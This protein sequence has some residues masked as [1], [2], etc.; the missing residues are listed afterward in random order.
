MVWF[1]WFLFIEYFI[2]NFDDF[3]FLIM[4]IDYYYKNKHHYSFNQNL[5]LFIK[6][7]IKSYKA[8]LACFYCFIIA[9]LGFILPFIWLVYWGLKDFKL[10]EA[11]FYIISFQTII[12]A[13]ITAL[14][15]TLLAYFLMFSSRIIKIIFSAYASLS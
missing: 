2:R 10:F 9:L 13:F 11:E 15:T 4:Y 1:K 6:K 12:L 8:I 5:T 14:I 3:C 7:E